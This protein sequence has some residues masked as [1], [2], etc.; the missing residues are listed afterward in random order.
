MAKNMDVPL[1]FDFYGDMLTDK[2]RSMIDL[3]YQQDLS[4]SEIAEIV[5]ISRQGVRDSVKRAE[6]QLF[7]MEAHLGL[8][9][10][11]KDIDAALDAIIDAASRIREENTHCGGPVSITE[12]ATRIVALANA[13]SER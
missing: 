12:Q 13:L 9:A 2:Q 4:L 3:Y 1:L 8:A 11:L 7:D 5:G 6:V 10:R